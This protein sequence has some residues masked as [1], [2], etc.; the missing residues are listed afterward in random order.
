[1]ND[2]IQEK[3]EDEYSE[4]KRNYYTEEEKKDKLNDI[5]ITQCIICLFIVVGIVVLNIF[6]PDI[7]SGLIERYKEYSGSTEVVTT[8]VTETSEST[9]E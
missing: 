3:Y 1:M 7:S 2:D 6:Y 4:I 9:S 8:E 5:V